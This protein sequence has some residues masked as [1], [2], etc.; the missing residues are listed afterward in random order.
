MIKAVLFDADGVLQETAAS[1]FTDIKSLASVERA[2]DFLEQVFATEG[3]ALIG[4]SNFRE[5]L[6]TLLKQL[7]A[8]DSVDEVLAMWHR[9]NLVPIIPVVF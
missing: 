7:Q 8:E 5:D 6:H 1:F 4:Q 2:D 3:P 9:I